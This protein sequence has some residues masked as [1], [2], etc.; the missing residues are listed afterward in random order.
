MLPSGND[1]AYALAEYF[2][3]QLYI[4]KYQ[5]MISNSKVMT[6]NLFNSHFAHTNI[7]YFLYE[8]N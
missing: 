7:K 8:M 5:K 3:N 1:A 6:M 2:G 4:R